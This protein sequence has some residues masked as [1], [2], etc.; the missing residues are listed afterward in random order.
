MFSR[1]LSFAAITGMLLAAGCGGGSSG[2]ALAPGALAPG[3][4]T[5]STQT[6]QSI[7]FSFPIANAGSVSSS[8][9]ARATASAV[10][11]AR[12]PQYIS[13]STTKVDLLLCEY[14]PGLTPASTGCNG[15]GVPPNPTPTFGLGSAATPFNFANAPST[16]PVT[17]ANCNATGAA[18]NPATGTCTASYVI[19]PGVG[20]MSTVTVTLAGLTTPTNTVIQIGLVTMDANGV[21]LSEGQ[22]TT[23]NS[24]PCG[25]ICAAGPTYVPLV[26]NPVPATSYLIGGPSTGVLGPANNT[27]LGNPITPAQQAAMGQSVVGSYE[28]AAFVADYDGNTI[29]AQVSGAG[30]PVNAGAPLPFPLPAELNFDGAVGTPASYG[31]NQSVPGVLNLTECLPSS[32][33]PVAPFPSYSTAT[34]PLPIAAGTPHCVLAAVPVFPPGPPAQFTAPGFLVTNAAVANLIPGMLA[35]GATSPNEAGLAVNMT[36]ATPGTTNVFL[37][38]YKSS[39]ANLNNAATTPVQGFTYTAANYPTS[40]VLGQP[41]N[42]T[43]GNQIT[44]NCSPSLILTVL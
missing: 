6:G 31:V 11:A 4:S 39:V 20:S 43:V 14:G 23:N 26:L 24:V 7:S 27:V 29:P 30:L 28:M 18:V 1:T 40:I 38:A 25:F 8:S 44:V 22:T 15:A 3:A 9:A 36:C 37:S 42:P 19:T 2:S 41:T 13:P 10:A 34:N 12:T 32:V 5:P 21:V 16:G 35:G 33:G 17:F